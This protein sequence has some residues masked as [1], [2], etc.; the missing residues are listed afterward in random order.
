MKK[1]NANLG[2]TVVFL[3]VIGL[4]VQVAQKYWPLMAVAGAF[5]VGIW[6]YRLRKRAKIAP[7]ARSPSTSEIGQRGTPPVSWQPFS[8]RRRGRVEAAAKPSTTGPPITTQPRDPIPVNVW[9]APP[10]TFILPRGDGSS[11]RAAPDQQ[12]TSPYIPPDRGTH[13]ATTGVDCH[14]LA[15]GKV[16]TV[17]GFRL[18]GGFLYVGSGL[19]GQDGYQIEAA[20]IDPQLPVARNDGDY[21]QRLLTYWPSYSSASPEA[22][23][24]YLRWLAAGRS[25]PQADIGYVFLYF[26]GLERRGLVDAGKNDNARMEIPSLTRE[27]ERLLAIYGENNSFNSYAGSLLS[28]LQATE[29]GNP[30]PASAPPAMS[31]REFTFAHKVALARFAAQGLP[32]PVEWALAWLNTDPTTRFRTAAVRC[33]EPFARAFAQQYAAEFGT[34]IKLPRNKTHL[35]LI[36][37]PASPTL[38]AGSREFERLF[39]LPDPTV[40]TSPLKKLQPLVESA[41]VLVD[42]YSR[43]LGRNP[44]L[45]STADALL[46]LPFSLWPE[47]L[48][49]PVENIGTLIR[50]SKMPL[51]VRFDKVK[52]WLP[53]WS[54]VSRK[55]YQSLVAT[56]GAAGMGIEPDPQFGGKLPDDG[57]TVVLFADEE[58]RTFQKPTPEYAAAALTLQLAASVSA[59]DGQVG[60]A[61]RLLLLHQ[62]EKWLHLSQSAKLRLHAHLRLLLAEPPGLNNLNKRIQAL[63]QANREEVGDF[64]ACVARADNQ[65]TPAEIKL[66][67]KIYRML[68]LDIQ[69]VYRNVHAAPS[70]PVTIKGG[71]V[72][73]TGCAIPKPLAPVGFSLNIDRIAALHADSEKVSAILGAIF[74]DD[75]AVAESG[76]VPVEPEEPPASDYC[77]FGLDEEHTAL[78]RLLVTRPEWTRSE[79]EDLAID[80][81]MMLDGAL[82]RLNEA[83]YD[84]WDQPFAEGDDTVEINPQ[85]AKELRS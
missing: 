83:S 44:D 75:T 36:Y 37:R 78:L 29:S 52:G 30:V 47:S 74:T 4:I 64:L 84:A 35:K 34:G 61:E 50:K 77:L 10:V 33:P 21:C 28:F 24:A 20:L 23:A 42:S 66:L 76:P 73:R 8:D 63:D 41:T 48:R 39:D 82:E 11:A 18:D 57:A 2:I 58:I 27:I 7:K 68:G 45:E 60:D 19:K 49:Q 40:L 14:W 70:A 46:E 65:V 1:K 9:Q 16:A 80:R 26:Y 25:D 5:A 55:K 31:T 53:Q 17:A 67:E 85:V 32:L 22:R 69:S 81:G 62:L 59:A 56:L 6:I 71:V 79:L 3:A 72:E 13:I 15:A 54:E 51:A 12:Q 38:L 43:Y